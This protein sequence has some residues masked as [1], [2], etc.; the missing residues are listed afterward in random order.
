MIKVNEKVKQETCGC[1]CG[2]GRKKKVAVLA[3]AFVAAVLV[4][5]CL[6]RMACCGTKTMVIDF[7]RVRQEAVAYKSIF[8]AQN[9]YLE[10]LEAQLGLEKGNLQKE[11]KELAEKKGKLSE[12]EFKKKALALQKKVIEFEQKRVARQQQ[13]AAASQIV[14]EQLQ[15]DVESALNAVAKKAGAGVV[16]NKEM[17]VYSGDK[18]DLTDAFIKALNDKVQPV[19]YPDPATIQ[20]TAGGQ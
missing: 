4:S 16:L 9:G 17:T 8:D 6:C 5:V 10:K 1:G 18:A 19:A 12:T 15:S 14:A 13:I 3:G 7:N 2:C 20:L 11:D